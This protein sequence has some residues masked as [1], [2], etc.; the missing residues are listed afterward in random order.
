LLG[1]LASEILHS[2]HFEERHSMNSYRTCFILALVLFAVAVH[3]QAAQSSFTYQGRLSNG[4]SLANGEYEMNFTLYDALTNGT[5]IGSQTVAPVPVTNGLFA[6]ALDF[7]SNAFNGGPRWLEIALTV[8][9]SDQPVTTLQ[10]RQPITATPYAL[11][12]A[13][14]AS[15]MSFENAPLEIKVNGIRALRIEPA[16]FLGWDTANIIGG[17]VRNTAATNIQG[18]FI[19]GGGLYGGSDDRYP[20]QVNADFGTVAGGYGNTVGDEAGFIGAGFNNRIASGAYFSAIGGGQLSRIENESYGSFIGGGIYSGIERNSEFSVV[21]GGYQNTVL[22]DSPSSVV[23]GG[24]W[25]FI[26]PDAESGTISGGISNRVLNPAATVGGGYQNLASGPSATVGGGF[27]NTSSGSG[28]STV[29][30][31]Y[32]NTSSGDGSTVA[33]GHQN[34][35]SGVAASV[36]GGFQNTNSGAYATIAGGAANTATAIRA[37]VA[38][39]NGNVA[40]GIAATIGGGDNNASSAMWATVSGGNE[41]SATGQQ[42]TVAG[43]WANTASGSQSTVAGGWANLAGAQYA[44]VGGGYLNQATGFVSTVTGGSYNQARGGASIVVGGSYNTTV[45]PSSV[46][47]GGLQNEAAADN[48]F[49]AGRGA[50][51]RHFGSFVW[52]DPLPTDPS[53]WWKAFPFTSETTNEFA[54][55]ATGG[56]RFVSGVNSTGA[57]IAG[58]S[59]APGAGG[60]SSLSDRN[61]KENIQPANARDILEKVAAL[62]VATWNYKSQDKS[63]RHI[64]PMAQDFRAAFGVGENERAISTVDAD[65][66]ALAAIRGLNEKM[67]QENLALRTALQLRQTE[68]E[69]LKQGL[70]E[71]RQLL[72]KE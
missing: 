46:A 63:I 15:L 7:G 31:G 70:T 1:R 61:A 32:Q 54:V 36:G 72:R 19:G 59:L 42:A 11:H 44:T 49:A 24:Y 58:V 68:I 2:L 13:N 39:G 66:V 69:E 57:P 6:V 21:S 8:F 41:N 65:G 3:V 51:A 10:P 33:G 28:A 38:G 60:W 55:R 40:S 43:G 34:F 37:T 20:N 4:G 52:A 23:A 50:Q 71:L 12:A 47:I 25:N 16:G 29:A 17:N 18:A 35:A 56:T 26:G 5:A 22:S 9:G 67:E 62:P 27:N 64:G 30:G 53:D 14:A 48:S 45:G